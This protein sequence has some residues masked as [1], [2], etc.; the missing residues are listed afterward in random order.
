MVLDAVRK[1]HVMAVLQN[2]AVACEAW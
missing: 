2:V 1:Y